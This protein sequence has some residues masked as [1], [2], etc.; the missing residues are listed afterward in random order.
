MG[1][2]N[3]RVGSLH[4]IDLAMALRGLQKL[5]SQRGEVRRLVGVLAAAWRE[6]QV[7][8]CCAV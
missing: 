7:R 1:R 8:A 5:S 6:R 3:I 2:G 4:N